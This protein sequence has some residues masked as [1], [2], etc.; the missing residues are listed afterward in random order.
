MRLAFVSFETIYHR[1]AEANARLAT[2]IDLLRERGH[3]VHVL[4]AAFWDGDHATFER[5]GVTYHGLVGDLE[6]ARSFLWRVPTALRRIGPDTVH[7]SA[8]PPA[9]V[10]AASAGAALARVPLLVE[11]Y[12]DEGID[13]GRWSRLAARRPDRIVTPSRLVRTWTREL[14]AE[15]ERVDVI[16]CPVDWSVIDGTEPAEGAEIVYARHLDE[17][18]NLESLM[19]ALAELRGRDWAATVIGDGPEREHYEDLARDLRIDE[20]VSFAGD[21]EREARVAAYK[22][23]HVFVQTATHCVFPTEL[24][25]ALACG[26]IGIV[27]YHANSS[28]HELVEGRERGFRTTTEREL[29]E[30]IVDAGDLEHRERDDAFE[31][32]GR[33]PTLER[34][35]QH[36]RDLQLEYGL[37]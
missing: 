29:V 7:A 37:L 35:L 21:L 2:V 13:E 15:G 20:R 33:R 27:E 14:G 23:A 4:C 28:A 31:P 12:G 30:T 19:L 6:S 22:N 10:A 9:Q 18:A 34:Y 17:G 5:D 1:D 25:W 24:A 32:F 26:C 36:Y 3:E 8:H 16:P 11:W